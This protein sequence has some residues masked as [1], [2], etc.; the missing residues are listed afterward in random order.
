MKKEMNK[1]NLVKEGIR[2]I[3]DTSVVSIQGPHAIGVSVSKGY[4]LFACLLSAI[5]NS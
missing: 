5:R 2:T 3:P 1:E 4:F